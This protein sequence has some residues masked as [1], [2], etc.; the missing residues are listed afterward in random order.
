MR[1]VGIADTDSYVKWAAALLA[2]A[3][4]DW[5][6][7]L[8]VL[9][10]PV[11]VSDA[12]LRAA[13][14]G[15]G[16][17]VDDVPRVSFDD[18]AARIAADPPDAVLLAARGP[19]VR[20]LARTVAEVT[21]TPVIV[22]GLPGISIPATRRALVYRVQAD[23][24][25]VHSHREVRAFAERSAV[26]GFAPVLGLASLPFATRGASGSGGDLVFAA[27]AKVPAERA[28]RL[29]VAWMLVR[30]ALADPSRRVVVK[31]RGAAGEHQTHAEQDPY[32]DLLASLGRRPA[33]L[34]LSTAPMSQAL[35]DAQGLVTVSSTA[36]I[37]AIARGIPVIAF[38][39]FGVSD[40]LINTVF[41]DSGLF[42]DEE[43]VVARRLRHPDPAWLRDNY[44]HDH[45]DDD[46]ARQLTGLVARRRADALPPRPP[47][48][49]RGGRVRD[50]W[51]R[52]RVL[53]PMDRSLGGAVAL[54]IGMPAR[55]AFRAWLR[56]RRA[57][58]P[59]P[60]PGR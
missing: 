10:T 30:A 14:A 48:R 36:A 34:V 32:P 27:Q 26:D 20:V 25:V 45:A 3:P 23:L 22:S 50:A 43:D 8:V 38:D 9:D 40:R 2:S 41:E 28:D 15:T 17:A 18:F 5:D 19:L 58:R 49:R 60:S 44:L 4:A 53:G 56:L 1:V 37:E 57:L 51:E 11:S 47:L 16:R 29:R 33:N 59:S 21:P 54:A 55:A 6:T 46:W 24:F 42:G 35:D 7:S 31:L 13:L 52:K 12:Q 39:G